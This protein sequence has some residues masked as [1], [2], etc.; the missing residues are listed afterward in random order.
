[1]E[2]TTDKPTEPG[3]YWIY[4]IPNWEDKPEIFCVYVNII[5]GIISFA[6]PAGGYESEDSI[7]PERTT[8]WMGPILMPEV[9]IETK[10]AKV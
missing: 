7:E 2:W 3:Y 6:I 5:R 1:M 10:Y 4:T 9:P 8:H